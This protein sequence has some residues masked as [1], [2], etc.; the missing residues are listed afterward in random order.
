MTAPAMAR[1]RALCGSITFSEL[2]V[3]S[4]LLNVIPNPAP[5]PNAQM[6]DALA[7][8]K[9][10]CRQ[11]KAYCDGNHA[12]G[13]EEDFPTANVPS[14]PQQQHDGKNQQKAAQHNQ[15]SAEIAG[16]IHVRLH[17]GSTMMLG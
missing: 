13:G 2:V 6:H 15:R 8:N 14:H 3:C 1:I 11:A 5:Q 17:V 12:H 4:S 7:L 10:P 16:V 9:P